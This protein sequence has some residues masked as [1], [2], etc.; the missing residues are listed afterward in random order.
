M[1]IELTD[2]EKRALEM[3]H[4]DSA[5][6]DVIGS[7]RDGKTVYEAISKELF[8]GKMTRQGV[9]E[10]V[11]QAERKQWRLNAKARYLRDLGVCPVEEL[12]IPSRIRN[13]LKRAGLTRVGQLAGMSRQELG[14]IDGVGR[15]QG[16][17]L[18]YGLLTSW[19]IK[20]RASS[21][22]PNCGAG[23]TKKFKEGA[24]GVSCSRCGTTSFV[25]RV[26]S[27]AVAV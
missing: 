17:F 18:L 22:C 12:P 7:V 6:P 9:Y 5:R 13:A 20:K 8:N 4:S 23:L 3:R 16:S 27:D 26:E 11:K 19:G 14:Q 15:R 10:L 21:F 24:D 2:K 1:E 25:K